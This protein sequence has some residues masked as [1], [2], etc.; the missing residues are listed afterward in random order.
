MFQMSSIFKDF[1]KSGREN[2]NPS[3]IEYRNDKP[4]N[5]ETIKI[6]AQVYGVVQGVGFRYTTKH[7]ADQLGINGIVR[8]EN[9]GSVYVEA[10]ASD[11]QIEQFIEELAKGPSPSAV[12]D[13][14]VI[15]YD[16]SITDYEGFGERH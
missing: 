3:E 7:L 13:K 1:F 9:D 11:N 2:K 15:E 14:V 8:N 16:D 5:T 10:L 12:V 4:E 6:K